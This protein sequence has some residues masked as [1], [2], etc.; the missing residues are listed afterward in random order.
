MKLTARFWTLES[1][2]RS[3]LVDAF[4]PVEHRLSEPRLKFFSRTRAQ[5][6]SPWPAYMAKHAQEEA[7]FPHSGVAF[8]DLER[9]L[10]G[11][12]GPFSLELPESAELCASC[13]ASVA[14]I[15]AVAA[16]AIN[17]TLAATPL[18]HA[19]VVRFYQ[20]D[21]RP[22]TNPRDAEFILAAH[23]QLTMWCGK[24]TAGRIGMLMVG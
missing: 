16:R 19:D 22:L 5:M 13:E 11:G 23:R 8:A 9:L 2:R 6:I 17:A 12:T 4:K 1:A 7:E 24:V 14:L 15:D 21:L 3:G 18:S 10:P 20:E